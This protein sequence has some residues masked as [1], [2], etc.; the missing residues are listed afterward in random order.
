MA[1]QLDR[2][3]LAEMTNADLDSVCGTVTVARGLAYARDGHVADLTVTANGR[4]ANA[5]VTG[6][7]AQPYRTTVT[8]HPV[9]TSPWLTTWASSCTCPMASDCKHVAATAIAC[10]AHRDENVPGPTPRWERALG[11]VLHGSQRE[12]WTPLGLLVE[13]QTTRP[14]TRRWTVSGPAR[15]TLV[16]RPVLPG[17]RGNWIRSGVSWESFAGGY[18]GYGHATF[19]PV[20]RDAM[21][22]LADA[23]RRATHAFGYG[24]MP[25]AVPLAALGSG[26][27]RLLREAH[28]S[29]I[30]LTTTARGNGQVRLS[31]QRAEFVF[32][33]S[34]T[35]ETGTGTLRPIIALPD[36]LTTAA[37]L[38]GE[39]ASGWFAW[40]GADLVL[41]AL[42]EPLDP[43]RQRLVDSGTL[44]IPAGDWDRFLAT[45][46]PVLQRT[47]PIR[48]VGDLEVPE[49][50]GPTLVC[51][52]RFEEGHRA[53]VHWS[54]RYGP[55][56]RALPLL[57]E[58]PDPLRDTPAERSL[59]ER[60]RPVL[61]LPALWQLMGM[62]R[63]LVPELVLHGFDTVEFT[64]A[65]PALT[66][67]DDVEVIVEGVPPRY[68]EA[69]QAPVIELSTT[70]ATAANERDWFDLGIAVTVGG[71]QVPLA[72]L[73]EALSR[74]ADRMLLDSGTWFTL[75]RPELE[76]LRQLLEEARDLRDRESGTIRLTLAH[77]GLWEELVALGV[78]DRQA[79]R[80]QEAVDRL[81]TAGSSPPPKPPAGLQATLRPYQVE[82]FSWLSLLWDVGL[83][84]ILAD[85]MGLGKTIQVLAMIQRAAE[86][87]ELT[88]PVLIVAP[89]SVL[90]TWQNEAARFTPSLHTV[91]LE[92]TRR[93][94]KVD[95]DEA[96]R[97]ADLVITSYAVARLDEAALGSRPWSALVL[98]EAQFVKNHQSKTY[99]V[100]RRL[101]TARRLALTGTP[102]ENSLMDLWS[103]LSIVAPGLFPRPQSFRDE[104]ARP[105][106][107]GADGDRL[108]TL[109]RR[110][111]PLMLRRT[112]DAVAADLPP[113]QEQVLMVDLHPRHRAIYDRHLSRERQRILGLL[114][115]LDGNRFAVLKAL[116]T[117]RQ[118][119]LDPALVDD[120]YLGVAPSAKVTTLVEL[121]TEVIAEGHRALVFS[122]F[123]GFLA[124]V[125]TALDAAGIEHAYLDGSTRRRPEVIEGFRDGDAP[126][127]L[128][129]L[130]A[131]GFGLT[132]TEADYV[133]VLDPW[134]NPAAENQAIDR[135]HRI[136]QDKPVNVYRLVSSH[137][138]EDKVRA[139][140]DRKRD[141]FARVV[142][143]GALLSSAVSAADLRDLLAR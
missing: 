110:I 69:Q 98:D 42:V 22:A 41:G 78:V 82:G 38:V 72:A 59:V 30:Q 74:G 122:Q 51:T 92:Q 9:P 6:S 108:A 27:F 143:E 65:L 125:R 68:A 44:E 131:G 56:G 3:T 7:A 4:S 61:T 114:E 13:E 97:D 136:G 120:T 81:Q 1:R 140:Q 70:E 24:R 79:D 99:Q 88:E 104:W 10:R 14:A 123:T 113:K 36:E 33:L 80:W 49:P 71:E 50:I 93:T 116:T 45:A 18:Y 15:P 17:A 20:V 142:D 29:G 16:L 26:W 117:L 76:T 130:K 91:V 8:L 138:I 85:D 137:T 25:N 73:I 62:A 112:K 133:F 101:P 58:G 129:S 46:L 63:G 60:V 127:F 64:Q 23:H 132:L 48:P 43:T 2:A 128:I 66:A 89:T 67:L 134:W 35:V 100:I 94:A 5:W 90:A 37:T 102:I 109:R 34:R 11:D 87:G 95:L 107:N 124:V 28:S 118:L 77:L 126:V 115:D 75:D 86:A 52:V 111:R 32:E 57:S 103:M 84:G 40:D 21:T 53:Y 47:A 19:S 31:E 135:T 119:A 105:I 106:E 96:I 141:L 54:F 121:L 39:P 12:E 139:L 55:Q 83:G